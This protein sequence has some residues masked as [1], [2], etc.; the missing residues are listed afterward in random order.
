MNQPPPQYVRD[1]QSKFRSSKDWREQ[2][3]LYAE[4]MTFMP[5]ALNYVTKALS[6]QVADQQ[7]VISY[8]ERLQ[9]EKASP[10]AA[11]LDLT[12]VGIIG[13]SLGGSAALESCST[14]IRCKAGVNLDGFHPRH[15]DLALQSTPFLFVNREDNL[16]YNTNFQSSK[17]PAYSALISGVT[18]FN[19]FD[20]AIMSP[21]YKR[22]GVLGP[23]D[24]V[25]GLNIIEAHVLA[26]FDEHL[27]DKPDAN[28]AAVASKYPEVKFT[29]R[30]EK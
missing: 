25:R 30:N 20:F 21:L 27:R 23:I 13:M 17:S 26:F 3:E 12:R 6:V 7:F 29:Q 1:V 2:V 14:D 10:L 4:A 22:L 8:L 11:H 28:L 24:G 15:I 16:L 5:E 18:H 9:R 19:F